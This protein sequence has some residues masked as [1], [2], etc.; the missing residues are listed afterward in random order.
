MKRN[1]ILFFYVI[2]MS[3]TLARHF[4]YLFIRDPLVIIKEYLHPTDDESS[5]HF[6]VSFDSVILI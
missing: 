6:E 1:K 4:G 3:S 5:Y 2:G